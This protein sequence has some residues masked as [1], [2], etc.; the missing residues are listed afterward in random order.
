MLY[1]RSEVDRPIPKGPATAVYVLYALSFFVGITAIIGVIIAHVKRSDVQG[2][3]L[4]SHFTWQ[5]RTF[6]WGFLWTA[7]SVIL[8]MIAV[9]YFLLLG[10]AVW[11]IYRITKGWLRLL[12]GRAMYAP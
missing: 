10:V 1:E 6:W 4:E 12:E 8:M 3:W 7:A 9:G 2:S 11:F 5:I